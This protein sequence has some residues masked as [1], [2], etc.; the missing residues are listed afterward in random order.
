MN[1]FKKVPW[2]ASI[3]ILLAVTA[4]WIWAITR[5]E[6]EFL[7]VFFFE[8]QF[9]RFSSGSFGRSRPFFFFT[10]VFLVAAFPWCLFLPATIKQAWKSSGTQKQKMLF[11]FCWLA[12]IFVFFS[13]PRS[14]L[15]YYI[16][17]ACVPMAV[18]AGVF[19][20][21]W[22]RG[23]LPL[24]E[25]WAQWSWKII[26][27]VFLLGVVGVNIAMLFSDRV[28]EMAIIR[29]WIPF[30][31]IFLALGGTLSATLV[32][33][34]P[35]SM[36]QPLV[37]WEWI[38]VVIDRITHSRWAMAAVRGSSSQN[39]VPGTLVDTGRNGPRISTGAPGLGSNV[40]CCGGPPAR[41]RTM[42]LRARG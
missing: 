14:K 25:G 2:L 10:Y 21:N 20:S 23:T 1:E 38:P 32:G 9:K 40:S 30:T 29:P 26:S 4:P 41:K 17:P 28:P 3:L 7:N 39:A 24:S 8:H 12:V 16:I 15:P 22:L 36:K 18:L 31:T 19:I 33:S 11:L 5:L 35:V 37:E 13:I 27:S 42:Q 34:W 6:P